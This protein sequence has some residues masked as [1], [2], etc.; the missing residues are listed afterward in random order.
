M[1]R[2]GLASRARA[3]CAHVQDN[4]ARPC[5]QRH[6]SSCSP[7]IPLRDGQ[8]TGDRRAHRHRPRR[9]PRARRFHRHLAAGPAQLQRAARRVSGGGAVRV[10]HAHRPAD[11][12]QRRL[13]RAAGD[14]H[15]ARLDAGS[16]AAGGGGGRQRRDLA[17]HRG[18]A[19]WGARGTRSLPGHHEQPDIRRRAAA[20][21]RNHRRRRRRGSRTST[22]A[23][24]CRLT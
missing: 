1:Q 21:L 13:P 24:R 17:M 7:G 2:H 10:P 18:C 16:R 14:H 5:A 11:S 12:A 22:A 4:A 9:A 19:V 6:L 15:S 3:T 20:V 23:T 8:W